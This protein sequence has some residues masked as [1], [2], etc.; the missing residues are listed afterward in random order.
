M[1]GSNFKNP[2]RNFFNTGN[3]QFI[4]NALDKFKSNDEPIM[5]IKQSKTLR[6][7]NNFGNSLT[8]GN[9]NKERR[10]R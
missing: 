10:S 5:P 4:K 9:T 6:K 7:S 3:S 1:E 2:L 8:K